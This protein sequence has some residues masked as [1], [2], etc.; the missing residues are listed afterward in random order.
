[1]RACADGLSASRKLAGFP[2]GTD[3]LEVVAAFAVDIDAAG[4]VGRF[5]VVLPVV[6][7]EPAFG[8]GDGDEVATA[9]VVEAGHVL[10]HLAE[11]LADAGGHFED[12]ADVV[13]DGGIVDVDVGELVVGDGEGFGAAE[14]ECFEAEFVFDGEP[15]ALAED[16]VEVVAGGPG[17][18]LEDALG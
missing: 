2:G 10:F 14:V 3:P 16:A 1:M 12:G 9:L 6:V 8:V 15:A 13:E 18:D 11:D 5:G 4:E 17:E 7:G